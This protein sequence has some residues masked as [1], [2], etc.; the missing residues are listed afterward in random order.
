MRTCFLIFL[1]GVLLTVVGGLAREIYPIEIVLTTTSDWTDVRFVGGT[2]VVHDQEILAGDE[3]DGLQVGALS[4]LSVS[5]RCC[6]IT[7]VQVLFYAYLSDPSEW[8]QMQIE[9]GHLGQTTIA[10]HVPGDPDPIATYT[11]VGVVENPDPANTRTFSI[12]SSSLTSLLTRVQPTS[13]SQAGFGEPKVLENPY[14]VIAQ[15]NFW[16]YGPGKFGGFEDSRGN[17]V[18]P[19]TPLLGE[20]Y[21]A[22]DPEVV[23][24]Q[25]EWAV[26]YGV[27]AFS[28]E[29][30]TP[31]GIGCCGSMEDTLD[32]VFLMSPNIHKIR[33]AIF[34]DF[35]L[36]LLQTQG[37][38]VDN[39]QGID[40]DQSDV[41]DTF[42][43]DFVHF[44]RKYFDQPQYLKIDGRPVIYIWATNSYDGDLAGAIQEARNRVADLGFDVY[45]VGDEIRTD[46]FDPHHVSIFDAA[47][48][49]TFLIPGIDAYALDDVGEAAREVDQTFTWW[50]TRMSGLRVAGR[51]ELVD[52]HSA[53]APQYDERYWIPDNPI[54]VPAMSRDQVVAMAEVTRRHAQ[55]VGST[56]QKYVWLN[57]WNNWA[58]TTTVEPTALIGPK[59]PAGNY[60]FDMLEI[61][62]EVFGCE[63]FFTTSCEPRAAP[64]V[65]DRDSDG[66]PDDEDWC[67]D[68]PGSEE[69]NGC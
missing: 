69:M 56:G 63:T 5:Q 66:V 8:M 60:G 38:D 1:V 9:K 51:Q 61:V 25:I 27:D 26:E 40:F 17:R 53:W 64:P 28:I 62:R 33:W 68:Y 44:A 21:W 46:H 35:V 52:F 2:I 22:A 50:R 6:D 20:T 12:R 65:A 30:T 7:P 15:L 29:W 32:D 57:T 13:S 18:T 45:I 37:L 23:H 67:P 19:L 58:E 47:T 10:L 3:A 55:P 59:Y 48:T 41:Y 42:V 49:F 11:H 54:Y 36:R 39:R 31:R 24:Q 4:T 34:Y 16:Y 43:S 14:I